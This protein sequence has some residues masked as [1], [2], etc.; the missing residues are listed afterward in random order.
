VIFFFDRSTGTAIP[1][2]LRDYLKPTDMQVEYH[3]LYFDPLEYD[4]VWL[5][6]VGDRGWFVIGQDYS[7]H[8]RR[9]ELA[10]IQTHGVGVFYLWGSEAPKWESLRAL[11]RGYDNILR[12]AAT[13][14]RPF[15]YRVHK[16]GGIQEV[17]LP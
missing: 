12:V 2:A 15:V 17:P 7:Y 6:Q 13:V 4:D 11:A 5:P 1:K 16:H 3:E 14:D 9:S 8:E 10:A